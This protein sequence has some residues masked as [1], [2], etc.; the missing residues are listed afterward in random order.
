MLPERTDAVVRLGAVVQ[1]TVPGSSANLGPGY[2]CVGLALS[3]HDVVRVEAR[4]EPGA[5]GAGRGRGGRPDR[6]R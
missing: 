3:V 1:V 5:A 2:D 4:D 6:H